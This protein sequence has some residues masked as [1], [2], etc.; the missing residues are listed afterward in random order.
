MSFFF[1]SCITSD[2]YFFAKLPSI[3]GYS[4]ALGGLILFKTSGGK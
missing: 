4:I 2:L 1:G 3:K